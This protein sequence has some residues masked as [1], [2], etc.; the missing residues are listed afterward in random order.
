MLRFEFVDLF[1]SFYIFLGEGCFNLPRTRLQLQ[2]FKAYSH[3]FRNRQEGAGGFGGR[4]V[5]MVIWQL[6]VFGRQ[7]F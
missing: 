2:D 6:S 4:G 3:A 7:E 5:A 1:I